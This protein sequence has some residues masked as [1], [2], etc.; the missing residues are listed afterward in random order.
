MWHIY[1]HLNHQ[2]TMWD[3][4][5]F[6][7]TM[8]ANIDVLWL[9]N[10]T[11]ATIATIMALQVVLECTEKN[12]LGFGIPIFVWLCCL[13]SEHCE[14]GA[15]MRMVQGTILLSSHKLV[16]ADRDKQDRCV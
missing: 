8:Y 5:A 10:T 1:T 13:S 12:R 16:H 7:M 4:P 9:W 6:A 11:I 15:K 3:V 14:I 2:N